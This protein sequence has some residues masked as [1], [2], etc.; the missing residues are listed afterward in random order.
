MSAT[1]TGQSS[2]LLVCVEKPIVATSA[3]P[4]DPHDPHVKDW[5]KFLNY[6]TAI[7]KNYFLEPTD[8]V[9]LFVND[10]EGRQFA[11]AIRDICEGRLGSQA[12]D[13]KL[14]CKIYEVSGRL[15][16]WNAVR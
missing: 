2:Y 3:N 10:A 11:G 4:D 14:A 6:S 8:N 1:G 9:W 12:M 16:T 7:P 15:E 13:L 5:L